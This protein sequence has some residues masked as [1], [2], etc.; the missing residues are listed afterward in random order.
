MI[1]DTS[2]FGIVRGEILMKLRRQYQE[3]DDGNVLLEICSGIDTLTASIG[4]P[5]S[6]CL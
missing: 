3:E 2:I 6:Q 5:T 1:T 4:L